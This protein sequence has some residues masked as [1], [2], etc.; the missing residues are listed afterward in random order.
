MRM[1]LRVSLLCGCFL[2]VHGVLWAQQKPEKAADADTSVT[3][4]QLISSVDPEYPEWA[5]KGKH[6]IQGTYVVGLIVGEDGRTRDVHVIRSPD[7]RL[8]EKAVDSV[9]Q[10][11]FKPAMKGNKPVAVQLAVEVEFVLLPKNG[12]SGK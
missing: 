3:P 4:P 12:S 8:D 7:K 11:K 2:F 10:W 9:K 6:P 5:R 1:L